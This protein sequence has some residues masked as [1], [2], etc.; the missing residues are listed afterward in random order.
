M[1]EGNIL[2]QHL[3]HEILYHLRYMSWQLS[4]AAYDLIFSGKAPSYG[5]GISLAAT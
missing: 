5:L 2:T 3:C 1:A 4:T